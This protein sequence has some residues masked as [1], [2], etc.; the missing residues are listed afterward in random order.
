MKPGTI[1]ICRA[2]NVCVPLPISPLIS[3]LLP[4]AV[5][6]PALTA[7]ASAFGIRESTV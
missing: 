5:N 2:S 7:N 4:T 3:A 1:V 6:R